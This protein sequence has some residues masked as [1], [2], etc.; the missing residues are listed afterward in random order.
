MQGQQISIDPAGKHARI[1]LFILQENYCW[2]PHKSNFCSNLLYLPQVRHYKPRIVYFLPHFSGGVYNQERLLLL[3]LDSLC[4]KQ[5]NLGR[6]SV[7]YNVEWVIMGHVWKGSKVNSNRWRFS[8]LTL[9]S[10]GVPY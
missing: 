2:Y 4:S 8:F 7:V 9:Q 3:L 1:A 6:R 10:I 5:G